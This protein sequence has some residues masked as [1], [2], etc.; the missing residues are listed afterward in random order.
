[1][2]D[3]N[4]KSIQGGTLFSKKKFKEALFFQK[5]FKEALFFQNKFKEA[6]NNGIH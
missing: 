3:V 5:K 2:N 4:E 6:L 1:V